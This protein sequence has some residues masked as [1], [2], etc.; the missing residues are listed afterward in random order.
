[1]LHSQ[2]LQLQMSELR[3]KIN[4]MNNSDDFDGDELEGLNKDYSKLEVRF[5][6]AIISESEEKEQTATEDLDSAGVEIRQLEQ[7]ISVAEYMSSA[8]VGKPLEGREAEYN[9]AN[10]LYGAGT[11]MPWIALL[12]KKERMAMRDEFRAATTAPDSEVIIASVLG[13]VFADTAADWLGVSFPS[14]PSGMSGYP[15]LTGGAVPVTGTDTVAANQTAATLTANELTPK[16]AAAEYLISIAD[17]TKFRQMEEALRMDLVSAGR[18]AM[19]LAV[20]SG[21]GGSGDVTGFE[22]ELTFPTNPTAVATFADY[23][24]AVYGAVDGRYAMSPAEIRMLVGS[25]TFKHAAALFQTGSGNSAADRMN[26]RVTPHMD[27][28]TNANIQKAIISRS[29]GRAV[30]PVWPTMSIIRDEFSAASTGQVKMI[31]NI[32]WNFKVLDESG[33]VPLRFKLA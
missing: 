12:S 19:D 31:L 30:A 26:A 2:K 23:L 29:R 3:N 5:Q 25:E 20:V 15:V 21:N 13:R 32:L 28:A 24:S 10:D 1:M 14:V 18:E 9:A 6:S 4:A 16:R 8:I 22:H 27:A 33:Y 11:Q 7:D 17:A